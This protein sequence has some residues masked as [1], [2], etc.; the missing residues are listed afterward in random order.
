MQHVFWL[1]ENK[2]AGR[3]GPDT[4]P[5][6]P[7]E[8]AQAGIGAILTVN[9]GRL[10]HAE[11]LQAAGIDYARISLSPNA[12]PRDGDLELCIEALPRA[13]AFLIQA[14]ESGRTPLIHCTSGKDR[15]GLLMCY[16]LCQCEAYK[17]RDA[18]NEL[19]RVRPTGLSAPEYEPFAEQVLSTCQG[20]RIRGYLGDSL[21][22]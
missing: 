14:I 15:T 12:P 3:A 13:L 8:L 20:H 16:Y 7:G 1:R 5:W 19:R 11:D 21:D 2:I 22:H 17:P 4:A 10:V 18:I 9:D 6:N